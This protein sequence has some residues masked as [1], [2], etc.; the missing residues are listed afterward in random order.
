MPKKNKLQPSEDLILILEYLKTA[1]KIYNSNKKM[2]DL[3][4]E[5]KNLQKDLIQIRHKLTN[6][7]IGAQYISLGEYDKITINDNQSS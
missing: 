5:I 1:R 6:V 7:P 4:I 3:D 2:K